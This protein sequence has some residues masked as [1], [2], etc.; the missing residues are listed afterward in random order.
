MIDDQ[1]SLLSFTK[2]L[3]PLVDWKPFAL[4]LPGITQSDV[5]IID[6]A[7]GNSIEALYK[8]WL[9]AN[10]HGSWRDVIT[11]LKECDEMELVNNIERKVT[12]PTK[13]KT[14]SAIFRAHS[15]ELTDSIST[16]ILRTS[17]ALHAEGLISLETKEDMDVTGVANYR[18]ATTLINSIDRQLRA[19]LDPKEYL[20]DICHVL[21]NQKYRTLTDIATS[22]LHELVPDNSANRVGYVSNAI[23]GEEVKPG[24][25]I[26]SQRWF[27]THHGIY[28]GEPDCEVIHFSGDETGSL[29]F[30][31]SSPHCQIRKTTL[32]KFRDGNRL[33]LVAYNCSVGSKISSILHS[34]YC[35]TEKAM[36]LSETIE[37][38]KYFLN[39]PKEFGEYDIANNNSETFACFCKTSL[40]NVAAQ[41]QP[42]RWIPLP[43]GSSV[44]NSQ[45]DTYVEALEKYHRIRCQNTT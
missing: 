37:L 45:C 43:A 27:H 28:I 4:F 40:M 15:V 18:K 2:Y 13:G 7:K 1:P 6:K 19:S 25:H 3:K 21:I 20:I 26:L 33:C 41:L 30:K 9:Q 23:T 31:R 34:A 44:V 29:E 38:A 42:T 39:H 24:D 35:H 12:D 22:I 10:P 11:A 14:P 36:P 17:N 5:K 8:S 32:D 16:S